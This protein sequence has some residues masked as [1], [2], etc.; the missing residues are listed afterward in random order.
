MIRGQDSS[1]EIMAQGVL[2]AGIKVVEFS[3]EEQSFRNRIHF[4]R[5]EL[6]QIQNGGKAHDV[7]GRRLCRTMRRDGILVL[8]HQYDSEKNQI[9][10]YLDLTEEAKA[11]VEDRLR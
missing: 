3:P 7:L 1:T 6:K 4:F 11:L 9:R 5:D 8:K 2:D 10:K